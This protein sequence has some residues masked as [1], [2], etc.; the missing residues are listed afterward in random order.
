MPDKQSPAHRTRLRSR[1]VCLFGGTFDPVHKAHLRMAVEA[2]DRFRLDQVL[3]VPAGHPPHKADSRVAPYLDRLAMVKLACKG[4]K[5]FVASELE[6]H[7]GKSFTID[8]VE[9]L[10]AQLNPRDRLFFLI[11]ADAFDDLRSWHRWR[12]MLSLTEFLVVTRPG[13]RYRIP[14]GAR[15]HSLDG[16]AMLASSSGIRSHLAAGEPA[17][18]IPKA[19][20]AYI[21]E[22]SLYGAVKSRYGRDGAAMLG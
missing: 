11:G 12:E 3:F 4:R 9:R 1:R 21:E 16:I 15:I 14:K 7:S 22:H 13:H 5:G 2:R 18:E 6:N 8:T 19:V 17:P 20:R 10:R